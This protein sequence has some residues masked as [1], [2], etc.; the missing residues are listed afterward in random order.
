MVASSTRSEGETELTFVEF[1]C[2][3]DPA[4]T[5]IETIL[6]HL[7]RTRGGLRIELDRLTTGLSGPAT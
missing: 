1:T 4:D 6:F 5:T 2:D 7:I 3:P